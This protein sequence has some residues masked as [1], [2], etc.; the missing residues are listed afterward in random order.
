M[1]ET[2]NF[3]KLMS[4]A[5]FRQIHQNLHFENEEVAIAEGWDVRGGPNR[6][7][8][9]KIRRVFALFFKGFRR[10]RAPGKQNAVDE[11]VSGTFFLK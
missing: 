6:D 4:L 7:A 5:R 11:S 10:F 2:P 1:Q 3:Q 9:Y 8:L